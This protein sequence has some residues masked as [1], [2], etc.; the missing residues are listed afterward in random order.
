MDKMGQEGEETIGLTGSPEIQ[1]LALPRL[2]DFVSKVLQNH[3]TH[4]H[5][6]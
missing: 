3:P 2:S 1:D 6:A 5:P 4:E